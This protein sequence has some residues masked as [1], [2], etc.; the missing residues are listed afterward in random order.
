[1][2]AA[3]VDVVDPQAPQEEAVAAVE[4]AVEAYRRRV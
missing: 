1:M 3:V 4:L 2:V